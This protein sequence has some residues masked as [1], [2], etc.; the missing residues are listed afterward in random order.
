[1]KLSIVTPTYN[2][3]HTL[4]QLYNSLLMQTCNSFEWIVV[5][6]G[7]TDDT[8][9][10]IAA[11][12][13][14]D[15]LDI[16][17]IYKENGGK[18]TALNTG[19]DKASGDMVIIVDSDDYLENHAVETITYYFEKYTD[20][21][22]ICGF[23]FLKTKTNGDNTGDKFLKDEEVS[24]YI[25]CR[26]N[27]DIKGDKAEVFFTNVLKKYPFPVFN[28]E[29]FI[30]EDIIW[31]EIAKKYDT[32]HIN[33]SLYVCEYLEGGLTDS[34]KRLKFAS[35]KGS[36]LRGK[37]MMYYRCNLKF[38][39]KGAIIYNCYKLESDNFK[40]STESFFDKV[41]IVLT[42]PL[43]YIFNLKWKKEI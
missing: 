35:P 6:D 41:L 38:R 42:K 12:K 3:A 33:K 17:Y 26:I 5:D 23:S 15:K 18:H 43:G 36:M 28:G 39:I 7:S 32:V 8:E 40:I 24:N 13:S 10:L 22:N 25:D 31:I 30:S 19:I 29:K 27:S 11:F 9:N 34:D 21:K 16:N 1:M 14:E 37:Q 4:G 2:R 20:N